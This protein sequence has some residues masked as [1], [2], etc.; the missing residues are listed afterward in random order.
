LKRRAIELY[1][2]QDEVDVF[3]RIEFELFA[4][5]IIPTSASLPL[6][7]DREILYVNLLPPRPPT[8]FSL[9]L[10]PPR[11]ENSLVAE[12]RRPGTGLPF[13]VVYH[14]ETLAPPVSDAELRYEAGAGSDAPPNGPKPRRLKSRFREHMSDNGSRHSRTLSANDNQGPKGPESPAN[15]TKSR[16][17]S[18]GGAKVWYK[19][20]EEGPAARED[21][22]PFTGRSL[23][24]VTN[25]ALATE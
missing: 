17:R 1:H 18:P 15:S 12:V 4:F 8:P 11:P 19:G 13:E 21:R 10:A 3:H 23:L 16:T 5:G 20:D 22:N 2:L 25:I 14:Q 9:T 6:L 7:K 24:A